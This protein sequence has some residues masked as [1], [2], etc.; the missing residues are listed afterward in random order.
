MK[1]EHVNLENILKMLTELNKLKNT[2]T[3]SF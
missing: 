2:L 1:H 3:S